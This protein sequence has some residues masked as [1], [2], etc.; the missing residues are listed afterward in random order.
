MRSFIFNMLLYIM[1]AVFA[2]VC[3]LLS[4]MPGRK[5]IMYG[6]S[7]Y[8]KTMMWLMKTVV[9]INV[10]VSGRER[11]PDGAV[12]IASKHQSYGDGYVMFSQF[13]D[14]SFVTGDHLE[15][16]MLIKRVLRKA[17]AVVID[18]CGGSD[19]RDRLQER[20]D[21]IRK[22]GR[23]L[24]IYPEG[25]LSQVGTQHRYRKGVYFMY[26]DFNCPVV[27]VATNLGQRWNQ[28]DWHKHAG[29]AQVEFLEPIPPGLDK[30]EFMLR[31]ETAIETRSKELLDL[32]D[33]G[34]LNPDD[35]GKLAE[36]DVARSKRIAKEDQ[37][38]NGEK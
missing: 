4:L 34:A 1:T 37:Q 31:L 27:P 35:I 18:S 12:I 15:K 8:T 3:V 30:D 36:N 13:F 32:E 23:R 9:R 19:V 33:L 28:N 17:G 26:R 6:L 7:A 25:H 29:N 38:D 10:S 5:P 14:L 20:A 22:E 21:I 11:V 24:L 2:V 16:F